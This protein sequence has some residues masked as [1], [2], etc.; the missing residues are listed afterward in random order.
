MPGVA[1]TVMRSFPMLRINRALMGWLPRPKR[2]PCP[3]TGVTTQDPARYRALN[4]DDKAARVANFHTST[5]HALRE[6]VGASGHQHPSDLSPEHLMIRINSREVRS[7]ASQ[8][9]WLEPGSL[10]SQK[11]AHPAF[12]KFWQM[13]RPDSFAPAA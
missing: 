5:L 7:A 9:D 10:L 13:A 4:V 11:T 3:P 6:T 1:A 12:A 2:Y 8:Y